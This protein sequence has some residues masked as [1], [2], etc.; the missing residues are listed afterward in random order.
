MFVEIHGES[1]DWSDVIC[2]RPLQEFH[3]VSRIYSS[4]VISILDPF[5]F[6]NYNP[7]CML[8]IRGLYFPEENGH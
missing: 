7:R 5:S 2:I 3:P 1:E 6:H 4:I 8:G